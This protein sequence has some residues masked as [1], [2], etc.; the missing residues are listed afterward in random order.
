LAVAIVAPPASALDL[1]ADEFLAKFKD[2]STIYSDQDGD[3]SL[4]PEALGDPINVGDEQRTLSQVTTIFDSGGGVVF[5]TS[6]TAELTTMLYDLA[7]VPTLVPGGVVIDFIP[8]GRNPITTDADLDSTGPDGVYGTADDPLDPTTAAPITFGGVLEIY[9]DTTKDYSQD[10]GGVG[11]YDAKLPSGVPVP[12]DAGNGP[13]FWTEG[14]A[15]HVAGGPGADTF[16]G[17]TD[18]SLWLGAVLVELQYLAN[19]GVIV[20]PATIGG[21]PFTPGTV[22]REVLD[23]SAGSGSGFAYMNAVGGSLA[24]SLLRGLAGPLADAAILFDL[25][26]PIVTSDPDGSIAAGLGQTGDETLSDTL[27]YQGLGQWQVDSEDPVVFAIIP[28]P[29]SMSLLGLSL[30][31]LLGARWRKKK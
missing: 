11:R 16:T 27:V 20:D 14:A 21:V 31:G 19:V 1:D 25:N 10:P 18:G 15:G 6:S 5:D 9:Q 22:L 4:E 3:G 26:T 12:L 30:V 2:V 23:F 28:E 13:S 17:A 7:A 8:A 24:P 29:T